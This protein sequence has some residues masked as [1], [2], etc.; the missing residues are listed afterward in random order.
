MMRKLITLALLSVF[1]VATALPW[2]ASGVH[3]NIADRT[4]HSNVLNQ[5]RVKKILNWF[6]AADSDRSLLSKSNM[7]Q[8]F[9]SN[10]NYT[11]NGVVAAQGTKALYQRFLKMSNNLAHY[12]VNFPLKAMVVN[13]NQAAFVYQLNAKQVDGHSYSDLIAITAHFDREG[14]VDQWHAIIERA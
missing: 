1:S 11:V 2:D 8:Y 14:R 6:N 5:Q 13:A 12:H 9:S 7:S 4:L 10:I 3:T